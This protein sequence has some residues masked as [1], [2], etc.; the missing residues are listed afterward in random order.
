M[1][2]RH[3]ESCPP[4]ESLPTHKID[5]A[6]GS[7]FEVPGVRGRMER[8]E[9][10][11]GLTLYRL[12][13]EALEDCALQMQGRFDEPWIGSAFHIQGR[14]KMV[15][16]NGQSHRLDPEVALLMRVDSS[17]TCFHLKAGELVRHIG[18]ATTLKALSQRYGGTLPE[19]LG[20][21][22]SA[23]GSA[24]HISAVSPSS[25]LRNLASLLFTPQTDGSCRNLMLEGYAGVFLA[26][27]IERHCSEP[28]PRPVFALWEE[29]ALADLLQWIKRSLAQPLSVPA[30][31]EKA[32]LKDSRLDQLFRHTLDK[33]CAEFIRHERMDLAHTLLRDGNHPV[34][35][36]AAR[37]GYNHVS[38]FSR[39]YKA[40]FGETPARTLRR[41]QTGR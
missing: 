13:F 38:N 16:P 30:L 15:L 2:D 10:P 11:S 17:G 41:A 12:E 25:R 29:Q 36:V 40:H 5:M 37:S 34:K 22:M 1:P 3:K 24:C 32:G 21:F 27:T 9:F 28:E 35:A 18:A 31:A 7:L 39:A 20:D 23:Y 8:L 4:S 19:D 6:G 33:S 26:E 14:S